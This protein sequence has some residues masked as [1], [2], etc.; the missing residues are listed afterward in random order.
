M[1]ALLPVA[2]ALARILAGA[3]PVEAETVP[4]TQAAGRTLAED[5]RALR[6]Q[7]PF[8]TSAMDGYAVRAAD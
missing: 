2:E 8:S 4:I 6:T 1:S 5:V 7:P 3:R